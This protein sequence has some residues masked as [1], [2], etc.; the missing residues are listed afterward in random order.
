M[1]GNI[2]IWA[3]GPED[4]PL[5]RILC[6][7]LMDLSKRKWGFPDLTWVVTRGGSHVSLGSPAWQ[8]ICKAWG[9]LKPLLHKSAPRN[10]EEWRS[11][12]LW[13]PHLHH[14]AETGVKCHSQAQHRLRSFGICYVRDILTPNGQ[15]QDW[16]DLDLDHNDTACR[17]AYHALRANL[18]IDPQSDQL[19]G[20]HWVF[21]G[22]DA[23]GYGGRIWQFDVQQQY[24]SC[25]WPR[26]CDTYQPVCTFVNYAGSIQNSPRSDIPNMAALHWVL[27]RLPTG[28]K[29]RR[30]HYGAWSPERGFLIQYHWSDLTPLLATST[31][32]LPSLQ[33]RQL[34]KPHLALRKWEGQ[35]ACHIPPE[36]WH[37]ISVKF[38]GANENIFLWQLV[39]R[40]IA[41]QRWRLPS[42]PATDASTWC[43]RCDGQLREDITHCIWSCPS[44]FRCWE[45]GMDLL[46]AISANHHRTGGLQITLSPAH[47]FLGQPLPVEWQ[48]PRR[49]WQVLRVVL[50]WQVWKSRN[51][52]FMAN[53]RSDHRRTIY[54]KILA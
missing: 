48:I 13:Q 42:L 46:L 30:R 15:L 23:S 22:K 41:T 3:V 4:H 12:P 39:Y 44:S 32:Q 38:W 52:H 51:E 40:V 37:K 54:S 1:A 50:C 8:N 36:V 19:P 33:A 34:Y 35:L 29:D 20:P 43:T 5:H 26:I 25:D 16:A 10:G 17:R 27:L 21:F 7:H 18:R 47:V 28:K 53:R 6:A 11:L 31:S 24:L 45:W 9:R 14:R 2:M 49:F